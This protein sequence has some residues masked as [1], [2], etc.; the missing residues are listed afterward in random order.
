LLA[1]ETCCSLSRKKLN[2]LTISSLEEF[3]DYFGKSAWKR[4]RSGEKRRKKKPQERRD[5]AA[6]VH[7]AVC[8]QYAN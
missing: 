2:V 3:V 7:H 1:R 4:K 6:C 5:P 8:F